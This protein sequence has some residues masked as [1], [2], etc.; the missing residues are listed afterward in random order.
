MKSEWTLVSMSTCCHPS[1]LPCQSVV[2]SP[3]MAVSSC[4]LQKLLLAFTSD[5]ATSWTDGMTTLYKDLGGLWPFDYSYFQTWNSSFLSH[6]SSCYF[7]LLFKLWMLKFG[8]LHHL[9]PP[10]TWEIFGVLFYLATLLFFLV[11]QA[12]YCGILIGDSLCINC[13]SIWNS[14]CHWKCHNQIHIVQYVSQPGDKQ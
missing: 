13:F 12:C 1:H 5:L 6:H 8:F 4:C 3:S 14:C 9:F 2:N 7:E 10:G 11:F